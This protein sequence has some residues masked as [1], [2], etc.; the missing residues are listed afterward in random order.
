MRLSGRI[1]LAYVPKFTADAIENIKRLPK[2]VKNRL[3]T[4]IEEV[5]CVNPIGCS[6]ELI[7][8]LAGFRSYHYE[9]YRIIYRE[10]EDLKAV[11]VVGIGKKDSDHY[12]EIYKKLEQLAGAGKIADSF[13][14]GL[15]KVAP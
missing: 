5:I 1:S 7:E 11:A 2:N 14:R 4:Q 13:L 15:R 3:R 12:A 10:Y 8:P 9:E 6:E